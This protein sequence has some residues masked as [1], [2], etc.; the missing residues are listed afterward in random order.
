MKNIFVNSSFMFLKRVDIKRGFLQ[1][2]PQ[3]SYSLHMWKS[4]FYDSPSSPWRC[5]KL[6]PK[7]CHFRSVIKAWLCKSARRYNSAMSHLY[8]WKLQDN[9]RIKHSGHQRLNYVLLTAAMDLGGA[10]GSVLPY[11]NKMGGLLNYF[12]TKEEYLTSYIEQ[13][14][15]GMIY[16]KRRIPC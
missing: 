12:L 13:N 3:N 10:D 9:G 1:I 7:V 8:C 11:R 14:Y 5:S 15:K 16:H 2:F 4:H 6:W